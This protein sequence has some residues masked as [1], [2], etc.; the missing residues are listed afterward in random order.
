M[1]ELRAQGV[2]AVATWEMR[3][4][5]SSE[6]AAPGLEISSLLDNLVMMGQVEIRSQY[7]RVLS[8]LKVR[9]RSFD[10]GAQEV[11]IDGHGLA[12]SGPFE[13]ATAVSIGIARPLE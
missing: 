10:A 7:K 3:N 4:L 11:V 8:V 12:I 2:T 13:P 5:S 1:N 9:D 6:V